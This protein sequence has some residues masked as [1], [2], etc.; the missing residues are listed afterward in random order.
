MPY[1][2]SWTVGPGEG[3]WEG[4]TTNA[5]VS[6]LSWRQFWPRCAFTYYE[7]WVFQLGRK[8]WDW[9][10]ECWRYLLILLS[11]WQKDKCWSVAEYLIRIWFIYFLLWNCDLILLFCFQVAKEFG[12][13]NNG[14]SVYLNRN[15][16]GEISPTMNKSMSLLKIK[17]VLVFAHFS[18]STFQ[19]IK[20][21]ERNVWLSDT[22]KHIYY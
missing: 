14:F 7:V 15:K 3:E 11:K 10:R 9:L 13:S 12:C 6:Q 17:C 5:V 18:S 2:E 1:F 8:G 16:T 22:L 4:E 20:I 21:M 19:T